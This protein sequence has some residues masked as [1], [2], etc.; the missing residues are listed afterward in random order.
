MTGTDLLAPAAWRLARCEPGAPAPTPDD[1]GWIP[2]AVPGTAALAWAA[3]Y[4]DAAARELDVDA[5]DW[6]FATS[7]EVGAP[8][9]HTLRLDG[10]ATQWSVSVD[11]DAVAEGTSMWQ[12]VE[13]VLDLGAGAHDVVLRCAALRPVLEGRRPRPR[14]RS[15]L[16]AESGLRWVRTSLLGRMPALAPTW[17]PAGP[18]RPMHLWASRELPPRL[19]DLTARLEDGDGVVDVV[20]RVGDVAEA[21]VH[22]GAVSVTVPVV[23]GEV[24]ATLRLPAAPLWWPRGYGGQP[25]VD[26]AVETVPGRRHL[27]RRIGFRT[28]SADRS[29][30]GFTLLVNDVPVFARGATW[31]PV[32]PVGLADDEELLRRDLDRAA[33]LGVTMLRVVGTHAYESAAFFDLCDERGI[34]V[35]QDAMLATL[36]PPDDPEWLAVVA[37]E[38]GTVLHGLQGRPSLAV[39]CG[40]TETLQQP[41]MMGLERDRRAVPVIEATLPTVVEAVVPG[42]PYVESSPSGGDLPTHNGQGVAHWFGVGG[43]RRP[44]EDVRRADV[45]FASE[46][47]ALATPP[48]RASLARL[49]PDGAGG[50]AWLAGVPRDRGADWDFLD[51]TDH[52][53]REVLGEDPASAGDERGL[54]LRRAAAAHV[55]SEVFSEWRRD[56]SRCAGGLV[57]E[58]RDR[59]PGPGW[60]LLDSAGR[61]KATWYAL[62]RVLAPTAVLLTDEGLDGVRAHVRHDGPGPLQGVLRV[63]A[64]GRHGALEVAEG[65]IAVPGHGAAS[66]TVDGVLGV[67]RDLTHAYRFGEPQYSALRVSLHDVGGHEVASAVRLLPDQRVRDLPD[68]GLVVEPAG[69][70]RVRVRAERL[71]AWVVVEAEGHVPD[72]AWFHLLP[73]ES[74]TVALAPVDASAGPMSVDAVTVRCLNGGGQ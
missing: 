42:T 67:F 23:D 56:G 20:A 26:V 62:R 40:G 72:D 31:S 3:A 34:L 61:P 8:G 60:G 1:A 69:E 17:A 9:P 6:W 39:V 25:L 57:L 21:T 12:P 30:G 14:W 66:R 16:V 64:L 38:V 37:D 59:V 70:G 11:G 33:A 53:V 49:L 46:C 55:M 68:P 4:G 19:L 28:V 41:T 29:D 48:E 35:W 44:L 65:E 27:L 58:W 63:S 10:V 13:A 71:A 15:R 5:W 73:G 51:V 32:D 22:A 74:R 45:R 54:D 18:W 36:D 47:L 43:Y 52:Y 2:A 24:R 50:E 7:V